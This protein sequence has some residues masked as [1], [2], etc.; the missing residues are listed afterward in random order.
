[1]RTEGWGTR[2]VTS[3]LN[4]V[5]RLYKVGASDGTIGYKARPITILS[6]VGE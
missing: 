6:R 1:M 3:D 5:W 4:V 2:D